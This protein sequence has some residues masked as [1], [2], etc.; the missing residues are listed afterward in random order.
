MNQD[1]QALFEEELRKLGMSYTHYVAHRRPPYNKFEANFVITF[2]DDP[3]IL[4]D[5]E[6]T[7]PPYIVSEVYV[8]FHRVMHS[9]TP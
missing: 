1:K 8:L 7:L 2:G 6:S 4:V 5:E 9:P 3:H